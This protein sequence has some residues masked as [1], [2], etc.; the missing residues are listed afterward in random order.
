[1]GR[2]HRVV[3]L[4]ILVLAGRPAGAGEPG[5][6]T[7]V[8]FEETLAAMRARHYGRRDVDII[9]TG[10]RPVG[11]TV[12]DFAVAED[13]ER[14]HFFYI[15]RRLQEGTPF[16]PGHEIYFGHASTVDFF[17][18]EVHEPVLLI[19]PGT[20]EGAHV[21]APCIVRRGDEFIMAYT[22]VNR[23]LS[24]DIGLASSADLFNWRR[25]DTNPISPCKDAPWAFWRPD[26][27]AS[28]RDPNLIEHDGRY[29]MTYTANTKEGASCIA[30]ASTADFL[31]WRDHGSICVGPSTG[32]EPRL[33][34]GHKQGSLES[35]NLVHR[36]GRWMLL[37]KAKV[38]DCDV[39]EWIIQSDRI[40]A[41]DFANRRP[42]WPGA[43][44]VEVVRSRGDHAL[45]AAFVDGHIRFGLVDWSDPEAT[46][47][48]VETSDELKAWMR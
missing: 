22:G 2:I 8:H 42:F 4:T 32:Y 47:R 13:N 9:T 43:V 16:Y 36:R 38:R 25:W 12:A 3:I 18:W 7:A 37:V 40:G 33:A 39:A 23:H 5:P 44:G 26:A 1:Y 20:W 21:W 45:L 30:L 15:E 28:C 41:F 31:A 11:G 17:R 35:A 24:Q 6:G 48:F 34:G 29:W 14:L 19:R 10:F 27:I 46:A